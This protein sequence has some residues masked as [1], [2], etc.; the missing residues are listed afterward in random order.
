VNLSLDLHRLLPIAAVGVVALAA[1]VLVAR[2]VGG[3][4]TAA[5]A[6]QVLDRAFQEEPK[7]AALNMRVG[8]SLEAA[9]RQ[10]T[11]ADTVVSGEAADTAAGKPDQER[12]RWSE[13]VAGQ[14]P[15]VLDQ[16]ATGG[17]GYIKVDGQWY[18][19]SPEQYKRV[20][21]SDAEDKTLVES[22]GFDPRHWL[23]DPK[24]ESTNTH[25]GGVV[26]NQISGD[27]NGDAVLT[28]L[29]FYEGA[30]SARAQQFADTIK[31]AAKKGHMDL[32]AGKQ[33]GI[34]RKL[35]VTAQADASKNVPPLR[36]TLTFAL[37]L[38]KVNQPV[39]VEEPKGA[40]PP[41][42]I[43]DIPKAKLGSQAD[44]ILG[45]SGNGK[46]SGTGGQRRTRQQ[47]HAAGTKARPSRQSYITCVQGAQDVAAL[48]RC[49]ALLP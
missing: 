46:P 19:L 43:A 10:I 13:Q 29:G 11:V 34:L 21:E 26:A 16:I 7:S 45:P 18:R 12:F 37:G 23:R 39:K 32:F 5:S 25:V 48:E 44:E 35:S 3:G 17:R 20:F 42:R 9:G 41:A 38:N 24:L 2:G 14:E 15:V 47:R 40:L 30:S 49:Q 33:D 8:F 6:R 31:G 36:G 27:V 28:D 4:S 1:A 22:L